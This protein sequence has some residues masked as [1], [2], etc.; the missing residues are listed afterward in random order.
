MTMAS[1]TRIYV[2]RDKELTP[3]AL[4][5]AS[6]QAQAIGHVVRSNYLAGVAGQRELVELVGKG[7]K[8][9]KAVGES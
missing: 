3:V 8:V 5:E 7:M 6:T 1:N 9:E 4:V 2:V